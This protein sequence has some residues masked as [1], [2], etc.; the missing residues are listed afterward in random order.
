MI[1]QNLINHESANFWAKY[2]RSK[3]LSINEVKGFHSTKVDEDGTKYWL[4][5]GL[6]HRDNDLPAVIYLSGIQEWYQYGKL[7]RDNDLPAI[8]GVHLDI[9]EHIHKEWYKNGNLHR[10]NDKPALIHTY[11]TVMKW[12]KDGKLHRENDLPASIE[13]DTDFSYQNCKWYK[14]GKLHRDGDNPAIDTFRHEEWYKDGK[15]HRDNDLPA[16]ISFGNKLWFKNGLL[17][18]DNDYTEHEQ[19]PAVIIVTNGYKKYKNLSVPASDEQNKIHQEW[20]ND[21]KVIKLINMY[22]EFIDNVAENDLSIYS[23]KYFCPIIIF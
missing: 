5:D 13:F 10:D 15:L 9:E 6:I 21:G 1:K 20:W 7:H 2:D 8:I 23:K 11:G 19:K 17:H 4:L 18:R 16:I 12:Y 22:G 14:Y 3:P